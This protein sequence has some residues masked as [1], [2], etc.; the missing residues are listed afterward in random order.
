MKLATLLRHAPCTGLCLLLAACGNGGSAIESLVP[1]V[2]GSLPAADTNRGTARLDDLDRDGVPAGIELMLGTDPDEI[3]SDHDGLSDHYE[4]WGY[5]GVP[6]GIVGDMSAI[7]DANGNGVIA[8]L[9]IGDMAGQV[10]RNASATI[11][12]ERV[13][14]SFPEAGTFLPNDIDGDGIPN[15]FE[16]SGFYVEF[17]DQQEP[18]F[19]KWTEGDYQKDYFKTDPTKWSTD[20]DPFSDWEESTKFNIDQR[21][22]SPGDHPNI[23]AYPDLHLLLDKYTITLNQDVVIESST[24][25]T[26][27]SS[28][29]NQTAAAWSKETITENLK[30]FGGYGNGS[31]G[32]PGVSTGEGGGSVG[33]QMRWSYKKTSNTLNQTTVTNDTSGLTAQ[34]WS[35]AR[36]VSGN[37]LEAAFVN[38]NLHMVNTGTLPADNVSAVC[39]LRL[40]NFIIESFLAG[41]GEN[42][43]LQGK[44]GTVIPLQ[45]STTGR[46][47]P[48]LPTGA[49][50]V[51]TMNQLRS[52]QSG[53]LSIEVVAFEADTVV[54]EIDPNTGRR[55]FLTTG[56]WS[57]YH[58]AIQNTSARLMLDF[59]DDPTYSPQLFNSPQLLNGI[60]VKRIDDIRVACFPLDGSYLG[61][62]PAVDLVDAFMWAFETRDSEIG[63][64]VTIRDPVSNWKHTSPIAA[65]EFGFDQQTVDM[66]LAD[67][68]RFS[69]LFTI[70]IEPGNPVERVYTCTAPPPGELASPQIYWALCDPQTRK[71]R[72]YSRDVRGIRE[73]RFKPDPKANYDGELMRVGYDPNDPEMAFFYTYDLPEQ[74][75]WTG[76]EQVVA[77]NTD[78]KRSELPVRI[79]GEE[80]GSLE[81][82]DSFGVLWDELAPYSQSFGF[83]NEIV[84]NS[85]YDLRFTQTRGPSNSLVLSIEP[86]GNGLVHDA[87][88]VVDPDD[89][90]G[91]P[92]L[93]G[94]GNVVYLIDYNYLRKQNYVGTPVG[95]T[96]FAGISEIP[97][98][99]RTYAFKSANGTLGVFKPVLIATPIGGGLYKYSVQKIDWRSYEGI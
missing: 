77:I 44:M 53:A 11:G 93:D 86:L 49:P 33:F 43:E 18:W 59:G 99:S 54:W 45:V 69:N 3:D 37:S 61:S 23:P 5:A 21:V 90:N 92:L 55:T 52:I 84:V 70:P 63:P 88:Y 22:K 41:N 8:L 58:N 66:I 81:R 57:A 31:I 46:S 65:W 14:V 78:E 96:V 10:L 83:D 97:P 2:L 80:L 67:P 13:R 48:E 42:G 25:N 7:P 62:P 85:P 32:I 68:Q 51:L 20:G 95:E 72:A 30:D 9:D 74:Y 16:L 75:V 26:S 1:E 36:A 64:V 50:L 79:L 17:D 28:W 19:V 4:L 34:E 60:P 29:T 98:V 39:N 38:L 76:F 27:Q 89:G 15:D 24:G 87:L 91:G 71:L 6:V 73:M 82:Q 40:G 12:E 94:S 47:T 56:D 35:S